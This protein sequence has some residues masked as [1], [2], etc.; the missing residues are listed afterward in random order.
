MD[1]KALEEH[2]KDSVMEE[3]AK[4]GFRK[5]VIRLYYPV[6]MLNNLFGTDYDAEEMQK[7]LTGFAGFVKERLGEIM[8]TH[9]KERFCLILPEET[10][11]YVHE[12][13]KEN[14]FIHQLVELVGKHG[15]TMNEILDLFHTYS[16]NIITEEMNNG[17]F[18]RLIRFADKPEDTYY[19]CFKDEGCHIIYHRFLP[20][21]YADFDF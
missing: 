11:V 14:E 18:D 5:E 4:L 20:E 2:I 13:K 9:K 12:H 16:E 6:G 3:Q 19:Y 1:Y 10:S 8:I 15:C 21:D 7:A 17:E